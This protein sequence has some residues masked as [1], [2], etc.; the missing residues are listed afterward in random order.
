MYEDNNKNKRKIL[1][2]SEI[3][4]DTIKYQ[5]LMKLVQIWLKYLE[6]LIFRLLIYIIVQYVKM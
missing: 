4:N 1:N 3:T 5:R 2:S 6:K